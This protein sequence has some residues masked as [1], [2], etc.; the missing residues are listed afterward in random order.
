M[1]KTRAIASAV[2]ATPKLSE[3]TRKESAGTSSLRSELV[4]III[5][6]LNEGERIAATL[7]HLRHLHHV[8]VIVADGGSQDRT[9]E[10]GNR[11]GVRMVLS[12]P[13]RATQMN[14]GAAS[15]LG[16]ILLF[17]HADTRLPE[18]FV[19]HV[20]SV[21]SYPN[22]VAGAFQLKIDAPHRALRWVEKLANWRST[23]LQMPY[24]DQ[25][26]FVRSEIF[27]AIGGFPELPIME[28]FEL[29]RRLRRKGRIGMAP[30]Q[31]L[32]SA[33]RWEE[34]GVLKTTLVNQL[35]ILAYLFGISPDQ[36]ACW[37]HRHR[38]QR[39]ISARSRDPG[40]RG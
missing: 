2:S 22:V 11:Y 26:I 7:E 18:D 40:S 36:I 23:V 28:D 17:L 15:A 14:A 19:R 29:I 12:A 35:A 32:T 33:R 25:A 27:R 4:S 38:D 34:L 16:G 8:E 5:P 6:T 24:G 39:I 10:L 3:L 1:G 9:R 37:Y 31:V 30:L 21:L 13:G 20:R